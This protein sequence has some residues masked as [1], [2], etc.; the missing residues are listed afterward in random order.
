MKEKLAVL[1]RE[2]NKTFH[3]LQR[4]E[5]AAKV[6]NHIKKTIAQ[7]NLLLGQEEAVKNHAGGLSQLSP[8]PP[9]EGQVGIFCPGSTTE[10]TPVLFKSGAFE[11]SLPETSCSRRIHQ[12][13]RR[14]LFNPM[15]PP[16]GRNCSLHSPSGAT[17]R[18]REMLSL[19]KRGEMAW[20]VH[21]GEHQRATNQ[22]SESPGFKRS[23][24]LLDAG[25][26]SLQASQGGSGDVSPK[27]SDP[28]DEEWMQ[29]DIPGV[30][31]AL[32]CFLPHLSPGSLLDP[33]SEERVSG[34][35]DSAAVSVSLC[36]SV[37]NGEKE[38]EQLGWGD[39]EDPERLA[40]PA[41]TPDAAQGDRTVPD[42]HR[43][44]M[45]NGE[46][47]SKKT[48]GEDEGHSLEVGPPPLGGLSPSKEVLGSCTMVEGLM[49]PLEYYVRMTRR[50]SRR[51]GEVNLEVVMQS[52]LGKGRKGRRVA[53]KE[54]AANRA[55]PSQELPESDSRLSSTPRLP[56]E[57]SG[58][59]PLSA[60]SAGSSRGCSQ[61]RRS[62]RLRR[63]TQQRTS[64]STDGGLSPPVGSPGLAA[65][66]LWRGLNSAAAALPL[67]PLGGEGS[68]LGWLPPGLSHQDF[69]LPDEDFGHLKSKKLKVRPEKLLGVWDAGGSSEGPPSP[70]G[71]AP[72]EE[73]AASGQILL[74]GTRGTP[75]TPSSRA[76]LLSPALD[77]GQSLL[78]TPDFPLVGAT[79]APLVSPDPLGASPLQAA[80]ARSA[81]PER[82]RGQPR[83]PGPAGISRRA[84]EE[85][86]SPP[87]KPLE[88]DQEPPRQSC[89]AEELQGEAPAGTL[90]EDNLKMT[91]KL[92]NASGSCLVDM[93][94]VWWEAADCAEL[95]VVTAEEMSISLWRPLDLGQWGTVHTWHFTKFPVIQIVALSGAH[96]VVGAVLGRLETAEIRLLFHS[97][98]GSCAK[99]ELLKA[100]NINAVLGLTDRKLVSS[101]WSLRGQE[102]EVFSFSEVGRSH[103]RWALMPPEETVLAFADVAGL[104]EALLGMTAMNCIVLWN[105]GTGQLLKK[106]PVEWSFP[107]SVCHKAYSDAGLLFLVFSHPHAEDS[108]LPGNPA[109]QI[110]ALNPKTA[111]S[112]G[113]MLLALPPSIQGR[114]L[115]RDVRGASA[116]AVLASGTIA[117]WDLFLGQC[118]ALLPP[119][120]GG[121]WSLARW[122]VTDTCLLA[123][124]ED[125]SVYLYEYTGACRPASCLPRTLEP[126]PSGGSSETAL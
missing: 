31:Q 126:N 21:E 23:S 25:Q 87:E 75:P 113:V 48:S 11:G 114:Y 69:H 56:G 62:L 58:S 52:Q 70:S 18:Q 50:L 49:F 55:Q 105:L 14:V 41:M 86:T 73:G 76:L 91:S 85:A 72:L 122:S 16:L 125:G 36:A 96:S 116:A 20:E 68:H 66:G 51:Q 124:Q 38:E 77:G 3:R 108:Q 17:G 19:A 103:K 8:E 13:G 27:M 115:E 15:E 44:D 119:N 29:T 63:R 32:P 64:S 1:K 35:E 74:S 10:T 117:V 39:K 67:T 104:Q 79:P 24:S 47:P 84:G 120:S 99:E 121:S 112:S 123:G 101:C 65:P 45:D 30:T 97:S 98:E 110:V 4:A 88:H 83:S 59:P 6:K 46:P 111:R 54:R 102:V 53:P 107:A 95:C 40:D 26:S 109:F 118:T 90:R 57:A 93:S 28:D 5:K 80:A 12:S 82:S 89:P 43:E 37:R 106:I 81:N 94:V 60:K 61:G 71:E 100:G 9:E 92:K 78:Q 7:Q 33:L 2:Y 42:Q 34:L 22:G